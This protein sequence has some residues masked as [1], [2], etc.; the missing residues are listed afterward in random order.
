MQKC[1]VKSSRS[2][3]SFARHGLFFHANNY[4][5]NA[6]RLNRHLNLRNRAFHQSTSRPVVLEAIQI[7]YQISQS[8]HSLSGTPWYLTIPLIAFLTRIFISLPIA[9]IQQRDTIQRVKL[10]PILQA[11]KFSFRREI[12]EKMGDQGPIQCQKLLRLK[13]REKRKELFTRYNCNFWKMSLGVVQIPV[14]L[15]IMDVLRRMVGQKLTTLTNFFDMDKLISNHM[16]IP[17]EL[18]LATEGALWFPDLIQPDPQ[19]ALPFILSGIFLLNIYAVQRSYLPLSK[20]Q[21]RFRRGM[22]VAALCVGPLLL[23]FP[24]ALMLFWISNSFFNWLQGWLL[25]YTMPVPTPIQPLIPV[26]P[27]RTGLCE[28]ELEKMKE[29]KTEI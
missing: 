29:I 11:W 1:I 23:N 4:S 25:A 17:V 13:L 12:L 24:S 26:R 3:F 28:R 7:T 21:I 14:F 20:W 2:T 10:I 9:I 19:L 27:W 16:A 18:D 22:G 6:E 8:I 5:L 15:S